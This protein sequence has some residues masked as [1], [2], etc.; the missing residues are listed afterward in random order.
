MEPC[1]TCYTR[2]ALMEKAQQWMVDLW[3]A[4]PK[5]L[6]PEQRDQWHRDEGFLALFIR[7]HFPIQ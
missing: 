7:A 1:V 5:D 6:S 3:G 2:E 4:S